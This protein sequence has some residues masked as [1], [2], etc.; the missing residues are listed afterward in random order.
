VQIGIVPSDLQRSIEFYRDTIGLPYK[1]RMPVR[2]GRTLHLFDAG[3]G[4]VKLL[5]RAD[6]PPSQASPPG[7]FDTATGMRWLTL[8]H[9]DLEGFAARVSAECPDAIWQLPVAEIRPGLWVCILEDP[10]GNAVELVERRP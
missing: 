7:P 3:D 6:G 9:D 8:D 1:G 2:E 4:I 10:D 5:E